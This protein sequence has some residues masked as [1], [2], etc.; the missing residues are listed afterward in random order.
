MLDYLAAL[1][2]GVDPRVRDELAERFDAQLDRPVHELSTGNRQKLGLIQAFMHEPELLI[3]DEP[4]AGL[5]P[6]VQQSFHALLGEVAAA[7]PH[8]L[9]LLAHA[10]RGRAGGATEWRSCAGA[11]WS[12]STRSRTCARSRSSAWRSSSAARRRASRRCARSRA[13]ARRALDGR[14]MVVAFEGSADPLVKAIARY[15]VRSIR[16]REED[17]EEIFLALLPRASGDERAGVRDGAA[18]AAWSRPCVT[19]LGML[20]VIVMVGALF[21]AVGDSIG[22]LDLPEGVADLLGGADYGTMAGWMRSEIGA[23]YGPL[24]IAAM[25]ITGAVGLDGGRGGGRDPRRWRWPTRSSAR[26]W[27][28]PRPRRVAVGVV[29]IALGTFARA[30]GRC[31]DRRRRHRPRRS[32]ARSPCT[33]RSSGCAVGAV[34]LALAAATGRKAV[35]AGG[36]GGVRACSAS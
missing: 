9:P 31:R 16:S 35:A 28:W 19:A 36:R 4:I 5:D 27:C 24:V 34:A 1:R 14:R 17:L 10:S 21:P 23:V 12:W 20:A 29:V 25:A 33:S 13:C 7:G 15:E 6:L 22:K 32:R 18:A 26:A 30:G 2:G 3:L 11:G 8:G